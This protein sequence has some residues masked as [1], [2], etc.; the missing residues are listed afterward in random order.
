VKVTFKELMESSYCPHSKWNQPYSRFRR[1]LLW[2]WS[3]YKGR[4]YM[5]RRSRILFNIELKRGR[6]YMNNLF[7]ELVK[8]PNPML[9]MI[10]K[11]DIWTGG[12]LP[13]PFNFGGTP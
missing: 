2:F 10:P 4:Q 8:S 7:A 11:D 3:L 1:I 9:G 13:T 5:Q 6:R 12:T